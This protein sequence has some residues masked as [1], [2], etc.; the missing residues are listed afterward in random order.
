MKK[1]ALFLYIVPIIFTLLIFP[2]SSDIST[3]QTLS[4]TV[5]RFHV[6][7]NSNATTD[8][9]V[10]LLIRDTILCYTAPLLEQATNAKEVKDILKPILPQLTTLANQV[11]SEQGFSYTASIHIE[12]TYFPVKQ[13]GSLLLPPG[14][15]E[16]LRIVLGEGSGRNWWCLVFPSLC[17]VDVS[18]GIVPEESKQDLE[19]NMNEE[20]YNLISSDTLKFKLKGSLK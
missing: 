20:D 12:K 4:K 8:Q 3:Q 1:Y 6:L 9:Q 15:Y 2:F 11:L 16:A 10:K 5:L 14:E 17:F 7:G 19:N 18:N 13:Y